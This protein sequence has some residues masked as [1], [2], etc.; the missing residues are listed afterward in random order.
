LWSI[1]STTPVQI[2]HN[3]QNRIDPVQPIVWNT[4]GVKPGSTQKKRGKNEEKWVV[5]SKIKCPY[6]LWLI[7]RGARQLPSAA[8]PPLGGC[9]QRH[10]SRGKWAVLMPLNFESAVAFIPWH[11]PIWIV[12]FHVTPLFASSSWLWSDPVG[13]RRRRDKALRRRAPSS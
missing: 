10:Y 4:H 3:R 6:G 12:A 11:S 9:A 5:Y 7:A 13:V 8:R 2:W 1:S